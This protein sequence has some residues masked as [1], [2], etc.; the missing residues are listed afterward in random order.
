MLDRD[1]SDLAVTP[2]LISRTT[3]AETSSSD[4]DKKFLNHVL[5][6]DH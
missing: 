2:L 6:G 4:Q 5:G 1:V 3:V